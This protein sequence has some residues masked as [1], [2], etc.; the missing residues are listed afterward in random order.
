M[1]RAEEL[2]RQ[3]EE[4]RGYSP[5]WLKEMAS[6]DPD[7]FE[8][9]DRIYELVGARSVHIPQKYKELMT[10]AVL[11]TR[12]EDFGIKSHIRRAFRLGCTK[13]EIVEAFQTV[14]FHTGALS[15]VHGMK[16][17]LEVMAEDA[18]ETGATGGSNPTRR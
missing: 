4:R 14:Y 7:F 1:S 5:F 16:G 18:G 13:E 10:V 17:L 12:M 6:I 11:A 3:A 9:Y 15:I 8:A 2:V